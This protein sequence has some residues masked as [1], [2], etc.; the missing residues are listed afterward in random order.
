MRPLGITHPLHHLVATV[1]ARRAADALVLESLAD[2]DAGRADLDA[3]VAVHAV[4]ETLRLAIRLAAARTARLAAL[5]VVGDDQRVAVEHRRLEPRV[6]AHVLAHLLAHESRVAIRREAVE[7]DPEGFPRPEVPGDGANAEILDRREIADERVARPQRDDEPRHVLQAL[8]DELLERQRRP[9]ETDPREALALDL[10][11]DPQE[12]VRVDRLRARVAA[13][14]AAGDGSEQE[15]RKCGDDQ[16][17]RQVDHVLRPEHQP[18]DVELAG[19]DFEQHRLPAVP[20][21][22]RQP[23]EDDLRGEHQ[24]PPP[25]REQARDRPRVDLLAD[26]V[27]ADLL[28]R[29]RSWLYRDDL[30][31]SVHGMEGGRPCRS[32]AR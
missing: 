23:V 5:D 3:D 25:V 10:A 16:E 19:G 27:K 31:G 20:A 1:D 15:Q 11:F 14:E 29:R 8:D 21:E 17:R 32:G 26:L 4:A 22:P 6:R 9:V 24:R 30:V 28:G 2:V 13:P 12:H 7:Q 18:E